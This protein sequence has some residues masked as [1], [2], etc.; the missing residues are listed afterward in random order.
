MKRIALLTSGCDA[1]GMNAAV[2]AAVRVGIAE[3][4]EVL[5]ICN[6]YAGL[7][8]GEIMQIGVRSVGGIIHLGGT[9]PGSACSPESKE[10]SVQLKALG[11]LCKKEIDP[12]LFE[13]ARVLAR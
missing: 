8:S 10:T 5:G 4:C 2:R 3:G 1:P 9:V 11:Q 7:V 6:G 13:L 12:S